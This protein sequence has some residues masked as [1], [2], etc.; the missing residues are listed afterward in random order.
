MHEINSRFPKIK[1]RSLDMEI[2]LPYGDEKVYVNV[3]DESFIGMIDPVAVEGSGEPD[4]EIKK[5]INNPFGDKKLEDIVD[6]TKKIAVIVDDGS[7]PTPISTILPVLMDRLE[8]SGAK[9]ENIKIVIALGSHRYMTEKEMEERV[10]SK[11]YP[12]YKVVNS[13]FKDPDKLVYVGDT[14]E[15]APII[16]TKDIMDVDVRIGVGNLVPH[17]VM[18]WGGGGKIL[19]PGVAGEDTVSYFH[20][21]ASL[22]DENMFG[23]KTTPIRIMMESWVDS[24]GLD[25]IINTI[26]TPD[27]KIYKVVAG[28]YI[29]AHQA[30]VEI[31]RK[32][33]GCKVDEKADLVIVSSHPADQD[34]WQS[35][36]ALYGAEPA[37]KGDRGGTM[38]LVSPNIEGIGPH[39]DY[40]EYMGRDDGDDVVRACIAGEEIKGDKLDI[41]V[42]NSMSKMRRRRKIIVVSDGVTKE[43]M[44]MC[45]CKHYPLSKLQEA[46]DE[47]ISEYKNCRVSA[48]SSGAETFLYD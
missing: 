40:P 4:K 32:V 17:P 31:G 22:I 16:A 15:G 30:G 44:E 18:G 11:I 13:E 47:A 7:R 21:K 9:A 42:G 48:L 5:A 43:E 2:T 38:I 12:K 1:E 19:Y 33:L 37:L 8:E 3:P 24:I 28:D 6:S 10:G 23:Q 25:F 39:P 45:G 27:L 14:E 36:K 46:V 35:P 20:L 26:L 34:F 29:L 41:A